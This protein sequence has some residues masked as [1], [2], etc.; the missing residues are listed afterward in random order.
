MAI[1]KVEPSLASPLLDTVTEK[2]VP[3][4]RRRCRKVAPLS[5]QFSGA[6]QEPL[7]PTVNVPRTGMD[8]FCT[9][10]Q[11]TVPVIPEVSTRRRG[12]LTVVGQRNV[13]R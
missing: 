12:K 6:V 11:E 4:A 2:M 7:K 3:S 1:T 5:S 10:R 8:A 9:S 13:T